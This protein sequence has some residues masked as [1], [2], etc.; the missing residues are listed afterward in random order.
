V[1]ADLVDSLPR[2]RR[3]SIYL[4]RKFLERGRTQFS[5]LFRHKRLGKEYPPLRRPRVVGPLSPGEEPLYARFPGVACREKEFDGANQLLA[6]P[7]REH[8]SRGRILREGRALW[9]TGR[10]RFTGL[11]V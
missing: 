8:F 10:G 9:S 1:P 5:E 4:N 6:V 11:A 3:N 7:T 2:P